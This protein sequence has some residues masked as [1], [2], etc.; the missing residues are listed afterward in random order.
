MNLTMDIGQPAKG[1]SFTSVDQKK[2]V[3][4]LR[5]LSTA[6]G[7]ALL[8]SQSGWSTSVQSSLWWAG[9]AFGTIC[10]FGRIWSILYIGPVKSLELV[11]NGPFA[12]TRNPL[13]FFSSIGAAGIGLMFGSIGAAVLLFALAAQIFAITARKEERFLDRRFGTAYRDYCRVTPR[14]WLN[15]LRFNLNRNLHLDAASIGRTLVDGMW[16]LAPL[17]IVVL[18]NDLHL[19]GVV[20]AL[21]TLY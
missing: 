6:L 1:A 18:L 20:A 3:F 11:R 16:F 14:F 15:P 13:Y 19:H 8:A 17:P 21:F 10:L 12:M 2:R 9:L 4:F 5:M 7:L